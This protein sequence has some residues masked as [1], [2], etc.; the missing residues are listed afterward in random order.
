MKYLIFLLQSAYIFYSLSKPRQDWLT[1]VVEV[2]YHCLC[3]YLVTI[4]LCRPGSFFVLSWICSWM[5][6]TKLRM[7][8]KMRML[9]TNLLLSCCFCGAELLLSESTTEFRNSSSQSRVPVWNLLAVVA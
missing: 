7:L 9:W 4:G 1:S 8:I 5:L 2:Y 6:L 3:K